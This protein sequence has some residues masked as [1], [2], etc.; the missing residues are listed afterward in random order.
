MVPHSTK[1]ILKGPSP[2]LVVISFLLDLT[3]TTL[4]KIGCFTMRPRLHGTEMV[5]G[6]SFFSVFLGFLFG[7][8]VVTLWILSSLPGQDIHLPPFPEADKAVHFGYFFIG[9]FLLAWLLRR[10]FRWRAGKQLCGALCAIA[11]IGALDEFH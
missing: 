8:W 6:S 2:Q 5:K 7:V 11:L 3:H 1:S 10:A 4:P 9:G